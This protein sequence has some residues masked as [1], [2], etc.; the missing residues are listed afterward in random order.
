MRSTYVLA[1]LLAITLAPSLGAAQSAPPATP[2]LPPAELIGRAEITPGVP[3]VGCQ[4][5]LEGVPIGATTDAAG[6][7]DLRGVPPGRWDVK[8]THST[9]GQARVW[10]GAMSAVITSCGTTSV[11]RTGGVSG[12]VTLNTT[13]DYDTAVV[14]I[15]ELNVY[16]QLNCGGGYILTDVA[17]GWRKLVVT[18]SSTSKEL[19]AFVEPAKITMKMNLVVPV[20][21][22]PPGT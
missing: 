18:T 21:V 12:R 10:C 9:Y 22:S 7:Y 19:W 13:A 4:V 11:T 1:V 3:C 6:N 15:P 14:G 17:P 8:I 5:V 20:V 16:A 2:S